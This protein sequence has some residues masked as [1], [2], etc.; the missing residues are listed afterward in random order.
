MKRISI[1]HACS[2]CGGM[3]KWD[4][5]DLDSLTTYRNTC[6]NCNGSGNESSTFFVGEEKHASCKGSGRTTSTRT[7]YGKNWLGERT[8][9]TITA[10]EKCIFCGGTGLQLH[11]ERFHDCAA[12]SGKK[13]SYVWVKSLFGKETEKWVACPTCDGTGKGEHYFVAVQLSRVPT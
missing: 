2:S 1:R 10:T 12:C 11:T 6:G 3:G 4:S 7:E 9:K 8:R 13:G 5:E